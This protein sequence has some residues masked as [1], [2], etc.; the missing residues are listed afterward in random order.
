MSAA[1]DVGLLK[2]NIEAIK[3]VLPPQAREMLDRMSDVLPRTVARRAKE[4]ESWLE[5]RS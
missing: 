3:D 4:L 2:V 1:R 5:A